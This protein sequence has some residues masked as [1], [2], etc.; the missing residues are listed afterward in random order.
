MATQSERT[1]TL[2]SL[3]AAARAAVVEALSSPVQPFSL[4]KARQYEAAL[5]DAQ[6]ALRRASWVVREDEADE[7]K[8]VIVEEV[9]DGCAIKATGGLL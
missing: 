8:H 3:I 7:A 6:A 9:M 1:Q 5:S 4:S 2:L